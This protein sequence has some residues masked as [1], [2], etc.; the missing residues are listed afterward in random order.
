MTENEIKENSDKV[1]DNIPEPVIIKRKGISIVW[2][3]PVIALLI[4]LWLVYKALSG[5][6]PEISITF[7]SAEGLEAGKTKIKY[8]DVEIGR[9][10][11]VRLS[12]DLKSV[13][14]T[15][16]LSKDSDKLLREGTR[17]WVVRPRIK[18]T[19][20]TGL[21]TLLSGVYIGIDPG[22]GDVFTDRFIALETPPVVMSDSPG[23]YFILHSDT[24]G[25]L[26]RG[27]PVY[28]RQMKAGEV[29]GFNLNPD[30]SGVSIKIFV[31]DPYYKFVWK[32]T[33]F[34]NDSGIDLTVDANGF[35][36][37]TESFVS[38][39]IG[40]IAFDTPVNLESGIP[41]NNG[42]EFLLYKNRESA[43]DKVY[44]DK[45]YY[46]LYFDESIRG[47]TVGAPVEFRGIR[48]GQVKDIKL[49][50]N[51]EDMKVKIPVLIEIEHDRVSVPG[52][53]VGDRLSN[54][55]MFVSRGLRAQLKLGNI[56]SGQL[57]VDLDFHPQSP[58]AKIN[59]DSKYPE[60]PTIHKSM[61][62]INRSLLKVVNKLQQ[63]PL[64]EIVDNF[65][66][67]LSGAEQ[68]MNSEDLRT[69]IT[70]FNEAAHHIGEFSESLN[71]DFYPR[72]S[73]AVTD[74]NTFTG[75]LNASSLPKIEAAVSEAHKTLE[76]FGK[77]VSRDSPLY[78]ELHKTL[79]ELSDAARSV[80]ILTDYLERHPDAL[81]H[82][83]Q[84]R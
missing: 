17:F 44:T 15:A 35:R 58:R 49:M 65:R 14:V 68:L 84:K 67:T 60:L 25:S 72:L 18:A 46:I 9:V 73:N 47:L 82:G 10:E 50:F 6:G 69:A 52:K 57:F 31:Y 21:G 41:V 34:W 7:P 5:I 77:I 54:M 62:I 42:A 22:K 61:E 53:E 30:N 56:I 23:R 83:K 20:I 37:S 13:V 8:K 45:E 11:D 4:A 55:E 76:E 38:F 63:M 33:K 27:S 36:V 40:G 74:I 48:L 78:N 79:A 51:R 71:S 1:T 70:S 19:G 28:Y 16:C 75:S 59:Y 2:A 81:I 43:H 39:V 64:D 66:K 29:L 3:V 80:R 12:D 24:L 32:N 26:D